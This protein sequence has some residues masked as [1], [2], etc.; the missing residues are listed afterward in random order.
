[1]VFLAFGAHVDFNDFRGQVTTVCEVFGLNRK[2]D[3][4]T[5]LLVHYL[6]HVGWNR[7]G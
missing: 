6:R 3:W 5:A 1:M 2:D 4:R 7:A